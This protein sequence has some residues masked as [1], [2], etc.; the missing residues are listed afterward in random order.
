MYGVLRLVQR[1]GV[2]VSCGPVQSPPHCT[3][4]NSLPING[5]CTNFILYTI[6][7]SGL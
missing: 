2:W 3:K 6:I 1:G 5:Q 7:A 4:R